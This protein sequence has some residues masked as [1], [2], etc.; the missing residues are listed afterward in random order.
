MTKEEKAKI[1]I[2]KYRIFSNKRPGALEIRGALIREGHLLEGEALIKI[3]LTRGGRLLERGAYWSWALI[4]ENTVFM[5]NI[6]VN[7][8]K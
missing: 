3:F 2:M 4:R 7:I 8:I 1:Q 5:L 6:N